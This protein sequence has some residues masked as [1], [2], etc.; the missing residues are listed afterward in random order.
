MVVSNK[1]EYNIIN[2]GIDNKTRGRLLNA[3]VMQQAEFYFI[4]N[5][6]KKINIY[7]VSFGVSFV[8]S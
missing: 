2:K 8:I 6:Q 3:Y 5:M 7:G 1:K 4:T